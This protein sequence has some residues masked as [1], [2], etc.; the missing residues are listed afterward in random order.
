MGVLTT[1][2]HGYTEINFSLHCKISNEKLAINNS[3]KDL[4]MLIANFAF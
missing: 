1:D 4:A 2:E 3:G